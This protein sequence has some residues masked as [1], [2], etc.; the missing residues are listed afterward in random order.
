[1][2]TA[3]VKAVVVMEAKTVCANLLVLIAVATTSN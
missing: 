3:N 2:K 1:V